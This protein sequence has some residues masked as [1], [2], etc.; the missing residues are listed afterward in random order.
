M[1]FYRGIRINDTEANKYFADWTVLGP[2]FGVRFNGR[3]EWLCVCQC[4]CG[5]IDVLYFNNLRRGMSTACKSC[6]NGKVSISRTRHGRSRTRVH[7]IWCGILTRCTN[8]NV[9]CWKNYGGRGIRICDRWLVFENFYEDMG[10]PPAGYEIDRIDPNGNYEPSNCRWV[11]IKQ[12][13]RNKRSV[14]KVLYRGQLMTTA[15][16]SELTGVK[17]DLIRN[18]IRKGWSIEAA[19]ETPSRAIA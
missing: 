12:Q 10:E 11:T 4:K 19:A 6:R 18:R 5:T 3:L 14:E 13:A 1:G 9:A 16:I 15:D 17:T 7:N 8:P 2:L